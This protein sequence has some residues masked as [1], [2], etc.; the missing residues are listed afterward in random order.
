MGRNHL[1][2]PW[3]PAI[4]SSQHCCSGGLATL[5]N[6]RQVRFTD[7]QTNDQICTNFDQIFA[8]GTA[9]AYTWIGLERE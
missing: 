9:L 7:R 4:H 2:H 3:S 8:A 5:A 6:P 1:G